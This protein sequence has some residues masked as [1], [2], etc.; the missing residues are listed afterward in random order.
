MAGLQELRIGLEPLL[1]SWRCGCPWT[2]SPS[3]LDSDAKLGVAVH[4]Y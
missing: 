3:S 1:F 4:R 2:S